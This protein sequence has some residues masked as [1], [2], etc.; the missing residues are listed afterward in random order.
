M[1]DEAARRE[2]L[3]LWLPPP[4]YDGPLDSKDYMNL[5]FT[6]YR[7]DY[8]PS[9]DSLWDQLLFD[10]KLK[11][12]ESIEDCFEENREIETEL[13]AVE[14]MLQLVHLDTRSDKEL[15][16]GLN[17]TELRK[18]FIGG[19]GGI[20]LNTN[21]SSHRV[22]LFADATVFAK[23]HNNKTPWIR[24]VQLDYEPA[25]HEIWRDPRF[26]NERQY[27]WGW[28]KLSLMGL[29]DF[30]SMLQVRDLSQLAPA[31]VTEESAAILDRGNEV[32]DTVN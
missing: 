18:V 19:I 5:G 27:F 10:L 13:E 17:D 3:S 14:K 12:K 20:P 9:T 2:R 16:D 23:L 30:W 8:S 4:G 6:V 29:F 1:R 28:L 7:T 24:A 32:N 31:M 22:S 26:I 15:L 21:K 25:R 11:L